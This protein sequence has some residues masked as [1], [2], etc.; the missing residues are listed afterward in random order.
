MSVNMWV[1]VLVRI[2]CWGLFTSS[3]RNSETEWLENMF[4]LKAYSHPSAVE[5]KA[6]IMEDKN[7][8]HKGNFRFC[9]RFHLV[10]MGLNCSQFSLVLNCRSVWKV[11]NLKKNRRNSDTFFILKERKSRRNNWVN[12]ILAQPL[13]KASILPLY[14]DIL[15]HHSF[16]IFVIVIHQCIVH[17][18]L[19][20]LY[21]I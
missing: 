16:H 3:K 1:H 8:K 21:C 10:W 7:D 12:H 14:L 19:S 13:L 5:T 11:V 2:C 6:K 20:Y 9:F 18:R 15:L 17:R 4:F